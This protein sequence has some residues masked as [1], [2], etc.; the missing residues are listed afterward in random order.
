LQISA[1]KIKLGRGFFES[2][3]MK[4][5]NLSLLR[6]GTIC[7]A[8]NLLIV[9]STFAQPLPSVVEDIDQLRQV[10]I[11]RTTGMDLPNPESIRT[12]AKLIFEKPLALRRE[13]ELA[14]LAREANF[15][16]NLV[17]AIGKGYSAERRENSRYDFIIKKLDPLAD[18]YIRMSNEFKS[19]R[20]QAY[21]SMAKKAEEKGHSI[22]AFFL[23]NDIFRLSQFSCSSEKR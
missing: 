2:V 22:K 17:D 15:Y 11:D 20:N 12:T 18:N 10:Q 13:E 4:I 7:F 23:Y 14:A 8:V 16:A 21:F 1:P 3:I 19:I 9:N 5:S 6:L